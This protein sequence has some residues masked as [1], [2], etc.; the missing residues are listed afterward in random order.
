MPDLE[1]LQI[2]ETAKITGSNSG[3]STSMTGVSTGGNSGIQNAP[4]RVFAVYVNFADP[5]SLARKAIST[6]VSIIMHSGSGRE[7]DA[8]I[9]EEQLVNKEGLVFIPDSPLVLARG[10]HL[11]VNLGKTSAFGAIASTTIHIGY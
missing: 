4:H 10:D 3:T 11:L 2:A 5:T 9:I 1:I 7:Y 6:G 8:V